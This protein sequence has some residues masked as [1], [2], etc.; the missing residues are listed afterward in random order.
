MRLVK[1]LRSL[2]TG[3]Q[4][5]LAAR[6]AARPWFTLYGSGVL[7][8][9]PA[10]SPNAEVRVSLRAPGEPTRTLPTG[11]TLTL[12]GTR[13]AHALFDPA[14]LAGHSTLTVSVAIGARTL[15]RHFEV[16]PGRYA[17]RI[18]GVRNYAVEGWISPLFAPRGGEPP[19]LVRLLVDGVEDGATSPDQFRRELMFGGV[20]GGWNG[21]R[22][23]V[24]PAALDGVPHHLSVR[25]ADTTIEFG[26]WAAKPKFHIDAASPNR[27]AGW[28]FDAASLDAPTSMRLV[29]GD[30]TLAEVATHFRPDLKAAHGRDATGFA[31]YDLEIDGDLDLIAGP[32]DGGVRIARFAT[33]TLA[34]RIAERRAEARAALLSEPLPETTLETRRAV[35]AKIVEVER[36]DPEV[37]MAERRDAAPPAPRS[38]APATPPP[39]CAIVPAYNGLADLKLCLASLIPHLRPGRIRAL[40]INDG[41]PDAA[42]GAY[43]AEVAAAAHPGLTILENP[44]NLGFIATVNRGFSLLDPGEDALLVNA[45]TILP[46]GVVERLSRHC[47]ARPG[48]ASVTPLSNNATILSFPSVTAVNPPAFGLDVAE[49]D[50]AFAE[51]GAP[52][53]EL[54]TGV[55]FCMHLNR[56]ALDEVG[57]FSPDWG[58]GYCEEVDWCLTAR[59]LGWIHLAAPDAYVVHEGSVSFGPAK[60]LEI[61]ATNHAR[62]EALYPEYVPEVEAFVKADPL[63]RTRIAVALRLL[64]GRF[65]RLTLH[66]SHGRGGGT[67]RYVRDMHGLSRDPRHALAVLAPLDDEG[68]DPRLEIRFDEDGFALTLGTAQVEDFLTGI[69]AAGVAIELHI[70]SRL[71]FDSGLLRSLVASRPY[72]VML[73]DFQWFCPRVHLIDGRDFYCGEPPPQVCQI[74]VTGGVPYSFGDQSALIED[75]L[76]TWLRF[77]AGILR[78]ARRLIAPSRDTAAR[79]VRR[80]GLQSVTALP[81]P[82]PE[83]KGSTRVIGR[84]AE[85]ARALTLAVVGAIGWHK[86]YNLLLRTVQQAALERAPLHVTVVGITADDARFIRHGN[87]AVSGRYRPSELQ[88]R[89]TAIGPDFVLLP[90][91]WPETY[92]YV[93]SEVWE[94]GYPVAAFDFGAPAE[95]IRAE[96]GG[97]LIPPTSDPHEL[98]AHLLAARGRLASVQPHAPARR[99]PLTLADYAHAGEAVTQSDVAEILGVSDGRRS[100]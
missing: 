96:G 9:M 61:L 77:N 12:G 48:I 72:D 11:R 32:K 54:P 81:H 83:P 76:A 60:R 87:A 15:R 75:D 7:V 53:V 99:A 57:S 14:L 70:N 52:P 29:S 73:H 13:Y 79:Y 93:L 37:L 63:A 80:F 94:A 1:N 19:P 44:Q 86:G 59:D 35:R 97:F 69:E 24:P 38:L 98:L 33:R 49:I 68:E 55:G 30:D 10:A 25:V 36:A 78:G 17:G 34:A 56:A 21:F 3:G 62:L 22:L 84:R 6:S 41:S 88:A 51:T 5:W 2:A 50:R 90:S 65:D 42:V 82:E 95:R 4:R 27:V 58:R 66:V 31:F 71:N 46:P 23:P 89:L 18:D 40:V 16:G 67:E 20:W 45:D 26:P 91:V 100:H 39:V 8:G 92:S 74:C 64:A 28:F 85:G 47:H 43:L